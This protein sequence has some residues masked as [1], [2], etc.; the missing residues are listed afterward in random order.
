M[1]ATF[2]DINPRTPLSKQLKE[3]PEESTAALTA[4]YDLPEFKE[5]LVN[6]PD[7]TEARI[8]LYRNQHI[9]GICLG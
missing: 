3:K 6:Y 9:D 7:G 1:V 8:A 4:Y 5:T 2:I